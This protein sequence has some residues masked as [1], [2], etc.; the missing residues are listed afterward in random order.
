[1]E[2]VLSPIEPDVVVDC[3]I[4]GA[5]FYKLV[6]GDWVYAGT[7]MPSFTPASIGDPLPSGVA[8]LLSLTTEQSK[9]RGRKYLPGLSELAQTAGEWTLTV[10]G[11][12]ADCILGWFTPFVSADPSDSYWL[13][14][15]VNKYG[16][17]VPF[18]GGLAVSVVPAYQRRRR[19]GV[20][21]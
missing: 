8:A 14:C 13:P 5:D 16:V 6:A 4:L 17:P 19:A 11:H 3:T 21:S 15:V 1:M 7:G 18:N 20:G 9:V 12:L 2:A 10:L